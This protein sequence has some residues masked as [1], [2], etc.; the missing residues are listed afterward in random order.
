MHMLLTENSFAIIL[1]EVYIEVVFFSVFS[2]H[3]TTWVK[4]PQV[5]SC[6]SPRQMKLWLESVYSV[7]RVK[8]WDSCSKSEDWF[9]W[10]VAWKSSGKIKP[11]RWRICCCPRDAQKKPCSKQKQHGIEVVTSMQ[12][13]RYPYNEPGI[14][15]NMPCPQENMPPKTRTQTNKLGN[16][17]KH[18]S[19]ISA[20]H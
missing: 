9:L 5:A 7:P 16:E 19:Y 8:A 20:I 11:T 18:I 3:N 2:G 6:P 15:F 10:E 17:C 13:I 14:D 12:L 4:T 1:V